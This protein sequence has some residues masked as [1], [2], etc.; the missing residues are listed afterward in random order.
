M[1][2]ILMLARSSLLVLGLAAPLVGAQSQPQTDATRRYPPL[3]EY[4]MPRDAE[5]ALAKTA[6][7]ASVVDRATIKTLTAA[8]YQVARAGDNG[9]TCL[10]MR[11]WTAP[12]YTP[13]PFR[14]FV[15]DATIRAPIC[16]DAVATETTLPYYELRSRLGM[17]GKTPDELAAA[18]QQAYATGT[19]P[20][21]DA[22]G[23]AYMF[24][25]AQQLGAGIGAFHPHVMVFVPGHD[26]AKLGGN[27]PMSG[28]PFLSDDAGTPFAVVVIPIDHALAI[29]PR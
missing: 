22:T 23:F 15:Y 13:A 20:H 1:R 16:F 28:Y 10:V 12:T 24:S 6:A 27:D 25:A 29:K 26:N 21:R 17:A 9:F 3:A 19:L 5:I 2:S 4:L 18:V 7:P 8:G 11:G 14:S